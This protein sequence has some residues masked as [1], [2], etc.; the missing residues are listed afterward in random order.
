MKWTK[1]QKWFFWIIGILSA[2]I[3]TYARHG[4]TWHTL[5]AFWMGASIGFVLGDLTRKTT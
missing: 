5:L 4:I 3:E 2:T 1:A